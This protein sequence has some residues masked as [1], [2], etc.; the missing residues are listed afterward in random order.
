MIEFYFSLPK[1][2]GCLSTS[3]CSLS[4]LE[5]LGDLGGNSIHVGGTLLGE[6]FSVDGG[7]SVLVLV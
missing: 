5:L 3:D 2:H 4:L 6:G 1:H 7:G